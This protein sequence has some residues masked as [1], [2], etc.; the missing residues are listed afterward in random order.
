LSE[1]RAIPTTRGPRATAPGARL[2]GTT[3]GDEV[4]VQLDGE[5]LSREQLSESPEDLERLEE[6][7]DIV[8]AARERSAEL[9]R[10]ATEQLGEMERA[11]HRAGFD[12][13]YAEGLQA[14][15]SELSSAL[16]LVQA[17]AREGKAIRDQLIESAEGELVTLVI[18]A[19]E[20]MVAIRVEQDPEL[21]IETVRRGLDRVGAQRVVRVRVHPDDAQAVRAWLEERGGDGPQWEL[22]AD[23]GV[24]V[25]GCVID[26]AAGE[27]NA[28]LDVQLAQ[29]AEQ[30]REAT[31]H[32]D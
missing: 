4:T 12:L 29:I 28:R 14:A 7:A 24:T 25:G 10:D 13:G 11:G 16:E 31:P 2:R 9:M 6:A 22:R 18:A 8:E 26:T 5:L 32:V 3:R 20:R 23:G 17:A 27:V 1:R 15:A 19:L 30:L 21:V